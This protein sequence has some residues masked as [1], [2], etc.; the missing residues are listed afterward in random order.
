MH[1]IIFSRYFSDQLTHGHSSVSNKYS[2][3]NNDENYEFWLVDN[4]A[5]SKFNILNSDD[6]LISKDK[7]LKIELNKYTDIISGNIY[8]NACFYSRKDDKL[9]E[10]CFNENFGENINIRREIIVKNK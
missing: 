3:I 7:Y 8:M 9:V 6:E 2:L 5:K 4:N 1:A 10:K